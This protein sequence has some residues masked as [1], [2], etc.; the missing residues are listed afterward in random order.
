MINFIMKIILSEIRTF[1]IGKLLSIPA[2]IYMLKVNNS[3]CDVFIV[4]FEHILH[5]V[6][7][8]YW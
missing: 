6:L 7:V 3:R 2:G 8:F 1:E 4:D 5:L